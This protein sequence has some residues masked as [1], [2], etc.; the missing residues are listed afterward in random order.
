[1]ILLNLVKNLIRSK[2]GEL[3]PILGI[4]MGFALIFLSLF[5]LKFIKVASNDPDGA[6]DMLFNGINRILDIL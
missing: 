4:L 3:H 5:T 2:K 1:M 6:I